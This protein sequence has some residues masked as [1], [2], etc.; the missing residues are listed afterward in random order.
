MIKITNLTQNIIFKLKYSKVIV[1]KWEKKKKKKE[2]TMK[3]VI[4]ILIAAE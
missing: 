4:N 3:Y 1:I 2:I